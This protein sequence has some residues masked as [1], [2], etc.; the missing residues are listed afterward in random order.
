MY[1]KTKLIQ[2]GLFFRFVKVFTLNICIVKGLLKQI[3]TSKK[4]LVF[5]E[6]IV[7][8]LFFAFIGKEQNSM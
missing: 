3:D 2:N 1:L 4:E 8:P 5:Q 7:V 6:S